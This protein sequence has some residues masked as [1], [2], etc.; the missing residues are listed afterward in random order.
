M[1]VEE[2]PAVCRQV[3]RQAGAAGSAA[4]LE[5]RLNSVAIEGMIDAHATETEVAVM[6]RPPVQG[7]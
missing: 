7:Y 1:G 4:C 2:D 5:L 3:Q 6:G